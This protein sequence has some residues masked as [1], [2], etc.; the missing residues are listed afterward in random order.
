[1][2]LVQTYGSIEKLYE[3]FDSAPI[4]GALRTKLDTG[5]EQAKMSYDLA[6]IHCDAP[7]EFKPEDALRQE[8]D[9]EALYSL[10]LKLEFTKLIERY[11]LSEPTP[12]TRFLS[13]DGHG[14]TGHRGKSCW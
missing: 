7:I 5:R 10:F 8:V 11:Q 13:A 6:T 1:M 12:K 14:R 9:R 4:K 2:N 3:N